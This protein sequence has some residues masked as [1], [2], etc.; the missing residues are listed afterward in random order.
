MPEETAD[1]RELNDA[2]PEAAEDH[3]EQVRDEPAAGQAEE[4]QPAA[5][6]PQEAE[7]PAG[8]AEEAVEEPQAEQ[9]PSFGVQ[10]EDAGALK[11]KVKVTVPEAMID[12]KREEMF[13]ELSTTAQVPGFRIGRAPKRLLVKRFGK[14]VDRDV[15]N[16]L[17]G[18]SLGSA[19]KE[20]V[21][22]V[23]GEPDLD[24][25][26]IEL[27]SSGDMSYEM[28]VEVAPEFE[29]PEL[30]G[31]AVTR[32]IVK[33]TD[34][35]IDEAIERMRLSQARYEAADEPA[36]EQDVV[37]IEAKIG[38]DGID[39][40]KTAA[41]LRVAPGQIEGL[42]LV[43]L[44]KELAG[45][46]TGQTVT[47]TV[48]VPGV[49]PNEAWQG[50]EATVELTLKEV[51]KRVLPEVDDEYAERAGYESLAELREALASRMGARLELE[52][53]RAVRDQVDEYLLDNTELD[54]PEGMAGRFADR[55]LQRQHVDMLEMGVPREEVEERMTE[56]KA[57]ADE[58]AKRELKLWFIYEKIADDR[59]IEVTEEEV[60]SRVAGM[61]ATY[62]RR[63]E[64][65]RQELDSDGT[66]RQ[67]EVAIREGKV[68]G[69]LL[70]SAVI[71]E[72]TDQA[73]AETAD[74][75]E[76]DEEK[77]QADAPPEDQ[78][79]EAKQ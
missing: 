79:E 57:Y 20:S 42:P 23:I 62:G 9:G 32:P 27:P 24:L 59:G 35:R 15:R 21:L 73:E 76:A 22:K 12:A 75:Q 78:E 43:D 4:A 50:K 1:P 7:E 69:A 17:I 8:E 53:D 39:E 40:L 6:E 44:G 70:D 19:L 45:K 61:A 16:A 58:Q 28:E 68:V 71:T 11:K 55:V 26:A 5:A 14:E 48:K 37:A 66:I 65:F 2:K 77:T 52:V 46:K 25:D 36:A 54:V 34:E 38:G 49:H 67:V 56:I 47:M 3:D 30:D 18:E 33:V 31:I 29:L 51:R 60:N 13:G 64:R 74:S 72:V 63:P 41:T 10:V